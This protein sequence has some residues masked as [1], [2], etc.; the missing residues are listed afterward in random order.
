MVWDVIEV[1]VGLCGVELGSVKMLEAEFFNLLRSTEIFLFACRPAT[2]NVS[3]RIWLG[4]TVDESDVKWHKIG[5]SA[6]ILKTFHR[7]WSGAISAPCHVISISKESCLIT[8]LLFVD[9]ESQLTTI[10]FEVT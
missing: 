9:K 8:V 1:S 5:E 6:D 2:F 7:Y 3:G 4:C 10:I